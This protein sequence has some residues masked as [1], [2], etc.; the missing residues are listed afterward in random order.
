MYYEI[1]ETTARA[2]WEMVHMSDY[3]K[4]RAT[5]EYRA[6]VDNAAVL[7]EQKK[8]TTS[9]FYYAKLDALLDSYARR[10]ADWTNAY[11]RN[12]ASCPSVLISGAGNFPTRKKEKQNAREGAL[13]EQ[14]R[15]IEKI[16]D[17]IRGIGT[18]PVDLTDPDARAILEDQRA[19]AQKLLD[20]AKA[21]NAYYRKHKTLD[22]CPGITEKEMEWLTRTGVFA[23]GDGTP[24][25]LYGCPFPAYEL[26]SRREKIK[27]IEARLAELD[28]LEQ[29]QNADDNETEF[30]GGRIVRNAA[31]N[32]LQI[33]FDDM[34]DAETRAALKAE[35][36]RWSTKNKAWQRQLT[37]NA[38]RAARRALKLN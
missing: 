8:Q 18:G 27:R 15:E 36:F 34:P 5:N 2:A 22:G 30:D 17:K 20:D 29:M 16:L 26:S 14:Y 38:E 4:D 25:A 33:I 32:R 11:N 23:S 31:E 35:A 12:E 3:E 7:V 19:T 28:R 21:A 37:E 10:L 24:I 9:S 13:W 1:N 6:A